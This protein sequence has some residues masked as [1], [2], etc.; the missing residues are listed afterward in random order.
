MFARICC[1]ALL[2]CVSA[3]AEE[4]A[5]T[6][7]VLVDANGKEHKLT[8]VKLNTC[9]RRLAFLADPKGVTDDA[10]RGPLALEIREPNSTSFAKGVTTIIPLSSIE[11]VKYDYDKQ[12]LSVAVKGQEPVTGTLQFQNINVIS[13]EGRTND[14][15]AKFAGGKKDGFRSIAWPNAKPMASRAVGTAWQVQIYHP[16]A[17]HPSIAVRNLKAIYSFPGGVEQL[18]DSLPVRKGEN[19]KFDSALK[20]LEMVAV[21]TNPSFQNA[22]V[23]VTLEGNPEKLIAVPLIND[24]G[25]R[26]GTLIGFIGEVDAG[27]KLFPLHC[28][29]VI[30]PAG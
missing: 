9:V 14:V 15:T 3:F 28:I 23:E 25:N 24:L 18:A 19:L 11:S 16:E 5:E 7:V 6:P 17:K 10:K 12:S 22:A 21:D 27:W 30:K 26:S 1:L 8:N 2:I 13:L 29:K 4:P 20:K